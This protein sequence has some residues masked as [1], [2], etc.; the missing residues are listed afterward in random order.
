M[1]YSN[2]ALW[3]AVVVSLVSLAM[4]YRDVEVLANQQYR[5]VNLLGDVITTRSAGESEKL[6]A[7]E[8]AVERLAQRADQVGQRLEEV[9]VRAFEAVNIAKSARRSLDFTN[10]NADANR[11]GL[12][13]V[14]LVAGPP[15]LLFYGRL[16]L[17]LTMAVG[18]LAWRLCRSA[19]QLARRV[20]QRPLVAQLST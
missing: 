12:G 5:I 2:V 11:A 14:A 7:L 15:V 10:E 19:W 4:I 6:A 8:A 1:K 13:A 16:A 9:D 18:R 17:M 3:I 20:W